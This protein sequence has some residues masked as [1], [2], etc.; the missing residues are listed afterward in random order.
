MNALVGGTIYTPEEVIASGVVVLDQTQILTVGTNQE[1]AVPPEAEIIDT[2]GKHIVPGYVDVH[3]HGLLGNDVMGS[4]LADVIRLLPRF[5]VTAFMATTVTLPRDEIIRALHTMADMLSE[6]PPGARCLG[7]HIEGPHLSPAKPG[8]ATASW[9][10]PL[11]REYFDA[12][13]EAAQGHIRMI[14]FAPEEGEAMSVIPHL[15][16]GGVIPVIGHSDATFDQVSK[17]VE[18]GLCHATHTYNAMRPLHH[19][20]PGVVGAVM[21]HEQIMAE[22]IA[23]GI[24][25][26]PAAMEILIRVKGLDHVVLISDGAPLAGLPD[27]EYEWEHKPVFVKDG[28]CRLADGTISGAHALLDSGVRNLVSEMGLPLEKALIPATSTAAASV[29]LDNKGQLRPGYDADLVVLDH[30]LQPEKTFVE[31]EMLWSRADPE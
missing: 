28:V 6:P 10:E 14:T 24:H 27:G 4:A 23:D 19:R 3:I 20:E 29:N 22:L 11:T 8:M 12:L 16:E 25:V 5:G 26:H 13:Q 1:G 17:A 9:F 21:H 31:G 2:T 30:D 18:L 7:I 15:V